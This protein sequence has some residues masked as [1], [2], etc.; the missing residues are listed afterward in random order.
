MYKRQDYAIEH[1]Q[2]I[3]KQEIQTAFIS[4]NCFDPAGN[5]KIINI[6]DITVCKKFMREKGFI[7]RTTDLF[8]KIFFAEEDEWFV[9][10][11]MENVPF[12]YNVVFN[13]HGHAEVVV[14]KE[15]LPM[16]RKCFTAI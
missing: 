10:Q 8:Y 4:N 7:Y 5:T 1:T 11:K 9:L 14:K 6:D 13:V 16:L 15:L 3:K 12:E 2:R